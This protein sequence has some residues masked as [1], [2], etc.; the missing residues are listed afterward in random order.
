M[1]PRL[2]E[3][4]KE[5]FARFRFATYTGKR[6]EYVFH[7]TRTLRRHKAG[8]RVKAFKGG[9]AK[10][11]KAAELPSTFRLHDLRH[12]RVTTWLAEGKPTAL[13]QAAMGHASITTT[14]K[15]LHLVPQHL[16]ALVE[17]G[18][19]REELRALAR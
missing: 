12:R 9:F 3:A 4:M 8:D 13:V 1:T 11:K 5:H 14:E 15:Y 16:T 6:S 10:A 2:Q 19:S 17:D 7:H 18:P